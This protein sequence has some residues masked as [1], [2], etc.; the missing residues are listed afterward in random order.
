MK[1]IHVFIHAFH[2]FLVSLLI[3]FKIG[4]VEKKEEKIANL[5]ENFLKELAADELAKEEQ[6]KKAAEKKKQKA[7]S[8]AVQ[9]IAAQKKKDKKEAAT[10]GADDDDDDTDLSTFVNKN[11]KTKKN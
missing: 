9:R 6:Q 7:K 11:R 1:N 4:A 3:S 10:A 5:D 2:F 8:K